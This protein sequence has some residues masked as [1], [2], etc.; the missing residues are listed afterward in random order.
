[1]LFLPT[2]LAFLTFS[3]PRS[4]GFM[5][6]SPPMV[7]HVAPR[8]STLRAVVDPFMDPV[9]TSSMPEAAQTAEQATSI[10]HSSPALTGILFYAVTM[11]MLTYWD[12]K[13]LPK[14]QDAGV[15]PDFPDSL[16]SQRLKTLSKEERDLPWPTPKT[17][18]LSAGKSLPPLEAI[19]KKA[20][21]V[22]SQLGVSFYVKAHENTELIPAHIPQSRPVDG[23]PF[24][25]DELRAVCRV[26]PEWSDYYGRRV[27]VC[28]R[29]TE[30]GEFSA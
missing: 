14:L 30:F 1:M 28:K 5:V 7:S 27:Y 20:V 13:V 12:E 24:D 9:F 4:H 21:K 25:A 3:L 6:V 22:G 16:R 18:Q 26:D 19:E 15:M 23:T 10:F 8:A 2:C 29:K 11:G 17:A